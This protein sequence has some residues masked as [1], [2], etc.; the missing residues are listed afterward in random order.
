M[1]VTNEN[2]QLEE[3]KIIQNKKLDIEKLTFLSKLKNEIPWETT[4]LTKTID[5]SAPKKF[6][7]KF[8]FLDQKKEKCEED[9]KIELENR[10]KE[11]LSIVIYLFL[12]SQ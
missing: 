6:L 2:T 3:E 4:N 12:Y 10:R 1:E 8:T 11:L 9:K 7:V 5:Y